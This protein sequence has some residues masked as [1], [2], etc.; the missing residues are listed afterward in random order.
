MQRAATNMAASVSFTSEVPVDLALSMPGSPT[1]S[2]KKPS[3]TTVET[4]V[5]T[6]ATVSA[7]EFADAVKGAAPSTLALDTLQLLRVVLDRLGGTAS[8]ND[9]SKAL[10]AFVEDGATDDL[11]ASDSL[12]SVRAGFDELWDQMDRRLMRFVASDFAVSETTM[13][14]DVVAC[15]VAALDDVLT[16]LR[17]QAGRKKFGNDALV[18]LSNAARRRCRFLTAY[19]EHDRSAPARRRAS[20]AQSLGAS[21][22]AVRR[23]SRGDALLTMSG[24]A[25]PQASAP[26]AQ[27]H[28]A[29]SL[30]LIDVS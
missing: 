24:S 17:T 21:Y 11:D 2:P 9:V 30:P 7:R 10:I 4:G 13:A 5:Q 1:K 14:R 12:L 16:Y 19:A 18:A 8:D 29:A 15:T 6:G 23:G 22:S 3:A 26:M 20:L 28:G 25:T 27:S